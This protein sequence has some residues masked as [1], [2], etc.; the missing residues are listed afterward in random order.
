MS[1][2]VSVKDENGNYKRVEVPLE[3]HQYIIQLEFFIQFP[4]YSKLLEAYP[5][6][7]YKGDKMLYNNPETS[8][9]QINNCEIGDGTKI[10]NFVNLYGCEIGENCFIGPFVEIQKGVKIGNNTRISSHTFIC[11]GVEIGSNCFIAH[12]VMFT[13]DKYTEGREDWVL[14]KTVVGDRV[15]IGSNATIL[16][17]F[18][19][20]DAVIG[21]GSVVTKDVKMGA[22]V[23]GNPAHKNEFYKNVNQASSAT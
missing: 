7:F 21:A 10:S 4:N 16:P 19:G 17:V 2:F 12:G 18:I 5:E 20:A 14:R 1:Y 11:E 22:T 9:K 3:V 23:Y 6:R 15:R 13:N 8:F